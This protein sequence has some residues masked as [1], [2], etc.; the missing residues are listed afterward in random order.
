M[1]N[2]YIYKETSKGNQLNDKQVTV[3]NIFQAVLKG[4]GHLTND[5]SFLSSSFISRQEAGTHVKIRT[6][7][8]VRL[9]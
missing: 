9:R 3:N 2:F 8:N 5:S 7:L 4:E 1:Q 6:G